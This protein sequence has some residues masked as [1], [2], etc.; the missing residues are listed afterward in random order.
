MSEADYKRFLAETLYSQ[1]SK[2]A[3]TGGR[4]LFD[5]PFLAKIK[6]IDNVTLEASK[7]L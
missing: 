2:D 4:K 1:K 6:F 5:D 3:Y 7:D